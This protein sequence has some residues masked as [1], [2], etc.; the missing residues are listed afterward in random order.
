MPVIQ[1]VEWLK[2][3]AQGH[4]NYFAVP[5]NGRHP[6]LPDKSAKY[7]VQGPETAH[8]EELSELG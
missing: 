8:P 3:V 7:L 2:R 5:G 1:Q 4:K 6:C